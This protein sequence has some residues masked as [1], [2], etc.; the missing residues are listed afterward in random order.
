MLLCID[1]GNTNIVIGVIDQDRIIRQWRIRTIK[2][3]T[4]DEIG[5]VILNLFQYSGIK[6]GD[7]KEVALASVVPSLARV[8]Q[9]S[10]PRYLNIHPFVIGPET[11]TGMPVQYD[12]PRDVGI[13][14]IINAVAGYERYH[15]GLIVIDF[16]TATTFDCVSGDGVFI[17]GVITP[18]LIIASDALFE[19]T[20][21]LP[22]I[23]T[24]TRP[25]SIIAKNTV[26]AMNAGIIYGYAGLV[27]GIVGRMKRE[28]GY[29]VKVL[30]TG[31]IAPLIAGESPAIDSIEEHLT[32]EGMKIIY[33][34]NR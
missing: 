34:R 22:R 27:D 10:L 32:L 24:F 1:I 25:G 30:A 21:K 13:D 7:I 3:A 9:E 4:V 14:R 31:G 20:S 5:M 28:F 11:K 8:M 12:N 23:E 16:G 2:D 15:T 6:P 26:S 33:E 19:K 29:E 17:G 18:G